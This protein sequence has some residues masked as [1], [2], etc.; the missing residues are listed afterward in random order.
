MNK[1]LNLLCSVIALLCF[2]SM[3][4]PVIAL[5]Y[6]AG[7]YYSASGNYE[8]DY[9]FSGDYYYAREY[10]SVSQYVF[11]VGSLLFRVALALSES[12]LICWAYYGVR[13]ESGKMGLA[14][15]VLNLVVSAVALISMLG[16]VGSCRWGVLVV[17]A[18]DAVA[19]VVLAA[20]TMLPE[21]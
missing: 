9:Y 7:E 18:L 3:F 17:L 2:V 5:R 11:T 15:A 16:F 12:L 8:S 20:N 19:A 6:P 4:M 13:G 14:A 10:W 1:Q 21:K